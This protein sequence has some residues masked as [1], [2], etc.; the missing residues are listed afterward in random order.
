VAR[1]LAEQL[2]WS[3]LDADDVLETRHGRSISQIFADEGEP[4]FRDKEAAILAELC[5]LRQHV[6]ATGGGV[7]LRAENRQRLREAGQVVWLTADPATIW[8][9]LQ[10]DAGTAE[11]R[12]ALTVGGLAE[13]EQ[14]LREREPLYRACAHL[15]VDTVARSAE[16]VAAAIRTQ[17][18][19]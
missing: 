3:A 19:A 6:I 16:E 2:G 7:I 18:V 14:L 4:G 10:K 17:G 1:L 5:G 15:V 8:Q 12:P 11:R 9:R 13:I